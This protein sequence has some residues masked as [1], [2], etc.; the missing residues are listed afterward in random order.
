MEA[1]RARLPSLR[2]SVSATTRAPREGEKEGASYFFLNRNEFESRLAGGGF[3][4]TR[5]Y[6]GNLYGTPRPFIEQ[7]EPRR[8]G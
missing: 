3:L 1:L 7:Y 8:D 6:N 2:Y 5:E 4:E